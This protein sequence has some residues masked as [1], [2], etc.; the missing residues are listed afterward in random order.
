VV[1]PTSGNYLLVDDLNKVFIVLTTFV[2]FTNQRL[3][4][5]YIAHEIETGKLTPAF[6]ALLS[7]DVSDP[8]VRDEPCAGRQQ[9]RLDVGRDR[10]SPP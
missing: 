10:A 3:R 2:G 9:H 7:R 8:D 1:E 6:V 4:A 5:S